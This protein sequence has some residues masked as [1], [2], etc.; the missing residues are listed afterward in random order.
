MK[1]SIGNTAI[2]FLGKQITRDL[3]KKN[4]M[5]HHFQHQT[6]KEKTT[7]MTTVFSDCA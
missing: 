1:K 4:K 5:F 3:N 7:G 2:S 6:I